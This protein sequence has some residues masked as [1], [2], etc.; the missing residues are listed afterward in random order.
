MKSHNRRRK[1]QQPMVVV[2]K[3]HVPPHDTIDLR[4]TVDEYE[5]IVSDFEARVKE[6][7]KIVCGWDIEIAKQHQTRHEMLRINVIVELR[8]FIL[9]WLSDQVLRSTKIAFTD[10]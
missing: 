1:P 3:Q 8:Q 9:W 6:Q 7:Q 2:N 4:D 10:G 5:R